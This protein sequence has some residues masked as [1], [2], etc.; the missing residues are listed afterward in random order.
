MITQHLEKMTEQSNSKIWHQ[1]I[2]QKFTSS[3]HRSIRTWLSFVQRGGGIKKRFQYCVDPSSLETFL[4]LRAIEGHSGGTHINPTLQDNVLLIV[5][6]VWSLTYTTRVN[7]NNIVTW[8]IQPNN[9]GWDCFRT[10]N[11]PE[12]LKT[13]NRLQEDFCAY[14]EVIHSY[15]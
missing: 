15:K 3:S 2:D 4:Y 6:H 5:Q 8:E 12:I 7:S 13:Q 11:L 14:L 10:L 9:A 1:Y